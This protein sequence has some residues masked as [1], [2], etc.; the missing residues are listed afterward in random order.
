MAVKVYGRSKSI[1]SIYRKMNQFGKNFDDIHDILAVRIITNSV[2]ECYKVLG[3]V[4]QH[5]TPLNNRFKDYIA[6][7]K[8]NLYQSLHTT[9]AA[10]DG[11]I[12]KCKFELKKWMS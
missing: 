5:Y 10:D 11:I 9:I 8:H 7:P 4:H 1:Y 2:D 6:T 3:F 12:L